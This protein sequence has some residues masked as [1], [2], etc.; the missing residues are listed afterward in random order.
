M[1]WFGPSALVELIERGDELQVKVARQRR[2]ID[3]VVLAAALS[4]FT[5]LFWHDRSWIYFVGL[6][7]ACAWGLSFWFGNPEEQLMVTE[8][9]IE[10]TGYFGGLSRDRIG[11][12]W[13]SISGLDYREGGEDEPSGLYARKAGWNATCLMTHVNKEQGEEII[14]AIYRRFPYVELAEDSGVWLPLGGKS[15]LTTLGLSK[16]DH[17]NSK[18]DFAD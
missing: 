4:V 12:P 7:F 6:L 2:G 17:K 8:K 15:G 1:K 11:L 5:F 3:F 18:D 10:A 16:P 9:G 14:T 13:S